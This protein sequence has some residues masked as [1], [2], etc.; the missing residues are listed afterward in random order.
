MNNKKSI[1]L[2]F[3]LT[4]KQDKMIWEKI[5]KL[6][7]QQDKGKSFIVKQAFVKHFVNE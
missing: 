3:D 1:T 7:F 4:D 6:S 5:K 2:N